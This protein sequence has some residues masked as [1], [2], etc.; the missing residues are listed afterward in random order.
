MM[1]L[2]I[3]GVAIHEKELH[4]YAIR[5]NGFTP[6]MPTLYRDGRRITKPW[7]VE[8]IFS[9]KEDAGSASANTD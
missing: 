3:D 8:M 5:W 7:R 6:A 1:D 2:V 9:V 4:R